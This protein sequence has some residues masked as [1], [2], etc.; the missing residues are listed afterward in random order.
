LTGVPCPFCG[1]TTALR[2]LGGGHVAQSLTAAPLG[3]TLVAASLLA[4]SKR[5]PAQL[6]LP[7]PVVVVGIGAEW[8]FEL[9]RFHIL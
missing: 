5:L 3:I 4:V 2:A 8:V 7:W 6:L 1:T 9:F